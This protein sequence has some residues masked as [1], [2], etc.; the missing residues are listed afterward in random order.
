MD[1]TQ[2]PPPVEQTAA[3]Q[4]ETSF[5]PKKR[6]AKK[7]VLSVFFIVILV[8]LGYG[9]TRRTLNLLR[10]RN[11]S[12]YLTP[13]VAD[14]AYDLA[15]TYTDVR[16][17][18]QVR[19]PSDFEVETETD[20]AFSPYSVTLRVPQ[21]ASRERYPNVLVTIKVM[22]NNSVGSNSRVAYLSQHGSGNFLLPFVYGMPY[23]SSETIEQDKTTY[24]VVDDFLGTMVKEY[25]IVTD[26]VVY[27]ISSPAKNTVA[28]AAPNDFSLLDA[29]A[30]TFRAQ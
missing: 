9:M 23:V 24:V 30:A 29:I 21:G 22:P 4:N 18:F 28:T 16:F 13:A 27:Q 10:Q 17:G 5:I 3:F 26:N 2:Q 25:E 12:Q 11:L 14:V 15:N 6:K 20:T 1:N 19:H 7:I 8:A